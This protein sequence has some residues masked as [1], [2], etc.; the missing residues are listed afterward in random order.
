MTLTITPA[1]GTAP[2]ITVDWGDGATDNLG[3]V[4]APR[5]ITH[6]YANPGVYSINVTAVSQTDS[7]STATTVT[8]GARPGPTV[9]VTTNG[10]KSS[11]TVFT[12]T[13]A[14]NTAVRNV[15]IDF[16]DGD[17]QDLGA[18]TTASQVSHQYQPGT[19]VAR[20]TQTDISGTQTF[21]TA[22]VTIAP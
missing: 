15:R 6:T 17:G 4:A 14:P 21:A 18:V 8:V 22:V 11:P 9:T 3:V 10:T 16:G 5:G 19:Y 2:R 7:F 13:P 1:A 20:V 12:V